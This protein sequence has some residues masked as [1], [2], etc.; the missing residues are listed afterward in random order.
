MVDDG[1]YWRM[2]H[3]LDEIKYLIEQYAMRNHAQ[4]QQQ[5]YDLYSSMY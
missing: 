2:E 3:Q 4:Q 1:P 5:G